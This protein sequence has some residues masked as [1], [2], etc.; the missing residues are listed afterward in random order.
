MF[1]T[2]E[3]NACI[4]NR[5]EKV[6]KNGIHK[7]WVFGITDEDNNYYDWKDSDLS[8]SADDTTQKM[9]IFTHLTLHCVKKIPKSVITNV[10]NDNIIKT[11]VG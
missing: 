2:E 7:Y 11:T 8:D 6:S 9:A 10:T 1:T 4:I 5:A 3:A